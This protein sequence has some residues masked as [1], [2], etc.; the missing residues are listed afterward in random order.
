MKTVAP[1]IRRAPASPGPSAVASQTSI[2]LE[3]DAVVFHGFSHSD[4]HRATSALRGELTRLIAERGLAPAERRAHAERIDAGLIRVAAGRP[5]LTGLR[6]A[7]AIH[8]GLV[9]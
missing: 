8:G 9:P 1:Q 4:A 7:R 3:I 5:E 6:A 2:A